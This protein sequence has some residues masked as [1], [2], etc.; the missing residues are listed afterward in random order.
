MRARRL[1]GDRSGPGAH[2]VALLAQVMAS[3]AQRYIFGH[4]A[5]EASAAGVD[6]TAWF[7][8]GL[9]ITAADSAPEPAG[10]AGK[11]TGS[12]HGVSVHLIVA[13]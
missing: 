2:A 1:T 10:Y 12:D 11:P 13:G 9:G 4:D 3:K 5:A 8:S 7:S 6:T